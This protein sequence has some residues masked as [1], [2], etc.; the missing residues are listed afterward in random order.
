MILSLKYGDLSGAVSEANKLASEIGQYCDDLSRKVQQKMYNVE[1]GMSSALNSADYY[2]RSKIN[3][4]RARQSNASNLASKTQNLLDTA[5]RVDADVERTIQQNQKSFFQKNPNLK[6]SNIR[7]FLTSFLC[8]MKK[9]PILGSLIK[10]KEF[11]DDAADA[12]LDT[13]KW[14]YKCG[15]G[16]QWIT[17]CLDIVVKI[18]LAAAAVV[19]FV[20]LVLTG[21]GIV[22]LIAGAILAVIA[23]VNA[24]T[25]V[26]TSIQAI[27]AGSDHP[28][29]SKIYSQRDTLAQVLREENF[30]DSW[31]SRYVDGR[32][33]NRLSNNAAFAI[34]AIEFACNVVMVIHDLKDVFK[35]LKNFFTAQN[36]NALGQFASG[37]HFTLDNLWR[38]LK[39]IPCKVKELPKT[40]V[41]FARQF[42]F[43]NLV[44]G[45][46]Q[47]PDKTWKVWTRLGDMRKGEYLIKLGKF[48]KGASKTVDWFNDVL[49]GNHDLKVFLAQR[50]TDGAF[51]NLELSETFKNV[52]A[53][54]D[55]IG[56]T[57]IITKGLDESIITLNYDGGLE[58]NKSIDFTFS[59]DKG[60]IQKLQDLIKKNTPVSPLFNIKAPHIIIP[61]INLAPKFESIYPYYELNY[62]I[63]A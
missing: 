12:L 15:G 26:G 4:L 6:A 8:D 37:R 20:G 11:I 54:L 63:A 47:M 10:G 57:D 21:A 39:A 36:R 52:K 27:Q 35:G 48:I 40:V 49:K 53:M 2:V 61:K 51:K 59:P 31:L 34:E 18:G 43:K 17:N 30:R 24:I 44:L 32:F 41:A 62:K 28:A 19:T 55:K 42:T 45:H 9:V 56:V 1:G 5:K 50:V 33:L 7:L 3:G 22:F 25:N 23:V 29:M 38:G 16:E 13:I 60:L 58:S 46:L 14:W